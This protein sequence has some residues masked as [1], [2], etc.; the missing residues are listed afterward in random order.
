MKY[1]LKFTSKFASSKTA[2]MN[3]FHTTYSNFVG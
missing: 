2:F 1:N 3:T